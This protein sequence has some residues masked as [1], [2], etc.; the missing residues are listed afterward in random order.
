VCNFSW[1]VGGRARNNNS[2]L[3][4]SPSG[5]PGAYQT[6]SYKPNISQPFENSAQELFIQRAVAGLSWRQ[7]SMVVGGIMMLMT[8]RHTIALHSL[9]PSCYCPLSRHKGEL[10]T[11]LTI[12]TKRSQL[13]SFATGN[14][15]AARF[16]C[17]PVEAAVQT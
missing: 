16:H 11:G 9:P 12:S 7:I 4:S 15:T 6:I 1:F 8:T 14:L 2:C 17:Q 3:E 5:N 10:M 13:Q